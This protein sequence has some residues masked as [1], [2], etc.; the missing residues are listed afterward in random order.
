MAKQKPR[1]RQDSLEKFLVY[2][3]GAAPDEFGLLPDAGGW[4]PLKELVGALRAEEGFGYVT[5]K[6]LLDLHNRLHHGSPVEVLD[7]KIRPRPGTVS[8]DDREGRESGP[9]VK[10][11]KLLYAGLRPSAWAHVS[12]N[13]LL[14]PA[15]Q[16]AVRLFPTVEAARKVALRFIP[17]P[18]MLT[19]QVK[20]AE[21]GGS[22]VRAVSELMWTAD[23]IKPEAI[24]GPPVPAA[25]EAP[26]PRKPEK[27]DPLPGAPTGLF[28]EPAVHHGKK[29]GKYQDSP[30]WKTTTRKDRRRDRE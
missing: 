5:E 25:P 28:V 19:V 10:T 4:V 6:S 21:D 27:S 3:L 2:A 15:G 24:S 8:P 16:A 11:P 20:K 9:L 17:E 22:V 26:S 29:K 13:G 23:R 12:E 7:N 30:D 14:P 18:V 1:Q